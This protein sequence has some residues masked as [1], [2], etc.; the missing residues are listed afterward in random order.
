MTF[1]NL[2]LVGA[3]LMFSAC[4]SIPSEVVTLSQTIGNDMKILNRSHL[5]AVK[6]YF[7]KMEDDINRFVDEKY[8]PFVIHHV[9]K[10]ELAEY[11]SGNKTSL[12]GIIELAGQKEGVEETSDA[13]AVM[14]EFHEA[15]RLQIEGRRNELLS[16]LES[17]KIEILKAVN[18]SYENVIDANTT[19]TVYL[20]SI[21]KIKETQQLA[22]S[23]IGLDGADAKIT[24]SLVKLS[25]EIDKA[26]EA[27]NKIDIKS[28]D[29]FQQ[30]EKVSEKIK[31][32]T[33]KK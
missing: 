6:I 5:D 26:M 16:P 10:S 21:R 11:K 18:R 32:L 28:D 1:R 29:A 12:Y 23:K 19:I 27:A 33:N 17:Q 24:E 7:T 14:Q 3:M 13:V 25:S 30:L 15:A 8:A 20:Q 22:L 9:L 2:F 4:A 31:E